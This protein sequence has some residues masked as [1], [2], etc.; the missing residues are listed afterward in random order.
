MNEGKKIRYDA[1][2]ASADATVPGFLARP[3]GAPVYY[4]FPIVPETMTD[5]WLY[6]AITEF[7]SAKHQ[8]EGDGFA[9]APDGSR[10]GLVWATDTAD[11][12]E[13]LPPDKE[14]WGVYGVRFIR[15]VSN[16]DD[17]IVNFRAILPK[18]RERFATIRKERR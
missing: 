15:P 5:G 10:A 6:G 18:L 4:G 9:V 8:T 17:L 13:I 12:Y 11:F 1:N 7:E 16:L 14:R 3:T 2:A